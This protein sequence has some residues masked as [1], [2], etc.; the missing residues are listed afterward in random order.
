VRAGNGTTTSTHADNQLR[1]YDPAGK[2]LSVTYP[3]DPGSLREVALTYDLLDRLTSETSAGVLHSYPA[4]DNAGNRL[5]VTYGRTGRH[6]VS[7]YDALNRLVTLTE[8]DSATAATGRDTTYAYDLGGNVT[9]KVLPNGNRTDTQRDFSNRT[10][11]IEERTTANALV[12]SYD[13]S[14]AVGSW[15]SSHDAAGN[16]LRCAETFTRSGMVNRV[17]V[18]DYDHVYRLATETI[19]PSGGAASVTGYV[20]D[21]ANNRTAKTVGSATTVYA[22]GDGTNARGNGV[23]HWPHKV[24]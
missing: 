21:K 5:Q 22:F 16:V 4:Y 15:P 20:Y 9:R 7:S 18:N 14:V 24:A 8:K 23:Q 11:L 10:L 17:V 6:L 3:N 19:T 2:L 13:Y 1:A 12:S